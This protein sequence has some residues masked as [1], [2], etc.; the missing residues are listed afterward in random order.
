MGH[1]RFRAQLLNADF[2]RRG[3]RMARRN[4]KYQL[5][6]INHR[7]AQLRLLRIEREY[8]EFHVVLEHIVRNV[9]AQRTPHRDLDR[10]MQAAKLTQH[11]QQVER[12]KFV[13]GD[14]ELALLQFAH[15]HQ[16]RLCVLPQVEQLLGVFLQDTS[17][18][19]EHALAG[20]TVEQRLADLQL[21]FADRLADRRLRAKQFFGRARKAAFASHC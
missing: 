7:R 5:V 21:K 12:G 15:L 3:Q 6:Q 1:E 4:N 19:S 9:T 14:R 16:R 8:S 18:V 10:G 13:G 17:G 11:G 2:A 20:R